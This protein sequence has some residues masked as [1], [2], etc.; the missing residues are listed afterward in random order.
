MRRGKEEMR[1][2]RR[3]ERWMEEIGKEREGRRVAGRMGG[4]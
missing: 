3:R 4:M 2:E 1:D